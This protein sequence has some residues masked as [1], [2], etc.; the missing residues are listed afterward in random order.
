MVLEIEQGHACFGVASPIILPQVIGDWQARICSQMPDE[1]CLE[2]GICSRVYMLMML[3]RAA[4]CFA[5]LPTVLNMDR[6]GRK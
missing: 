2:C 6:E 1:M 3:R 4:Q 5:V